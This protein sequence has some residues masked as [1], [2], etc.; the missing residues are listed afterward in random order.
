MPPR[1]P[2]LVLPLLQ[3]LSPATPLNNKRKT[4]SSKGKNA[5]PKPAKRVKS[6]KVATLAQA[7]SSTE[8][9]EGEGEEGDEHEDQAAATRLAWTQEMEDELVDSLV[10][11]LDAGLR[12]QGGFKKP[13]WTAVVAEVAK[14]MPSDQVALLNVDKLKSKYRNLKR[15]YGEWL[16]LKEQSGFG[17]D[18][19]TNAPNADEDTWA[20]YVAA[21]PF[22][23]QWRNG[24]PVKEFELSRLFDGHMATGKQAVTP[25]DIISSIE[26]A[27]SPPSQS[28][29]SLASPMPESLSRTVINKNHRR[30]KAEAIQDNANSLASALNR[31]TDAYEARRTPIE[32]AT[33]I[34]W[35][36]DALAEVPEEDKLDALEAL[37]EDRNAQ[38]FIST[39]PER[40][41][42]TLAKLVTI[43]MNRRS[44]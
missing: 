25:A 5:T 16:A 29:S 21:H 31:Q 33:E 2:S 22:A 42:L 8:E 43:T 7:V 36:N 38:I 20:T 12:A 41:R 15:D 3:P 24:G 28:L 27:S 30:S 13:A 40:L 9:S 26:D 17:I 6:A 11:A 4:T 37:M 1:S 14:V 10:T 44:L 35:S 34:L 23:A 32:R 18:P 39:P 19:E